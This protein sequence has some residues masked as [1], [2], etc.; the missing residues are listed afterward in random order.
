MLEGLTAGWEAIFQWPTIL[1]PLL[2]ALLGM[3]F[4]ALPGLG[5]PTVLAVLIPLTFR[6]Q[7][8]AAL[9]L[10]AS[11]LGGVAFGGS[12]SAILL[13]TPGDSINAATCFDGYPLAQQGKAGMA[14]GASACASALG[15]LFGL[16]VLI[17]LLPLTRQI[18]LA[19]SYPELV[20]VALLGL[21][22]IAAVSESGR[23]KGLLM[24]GVG[25]ML[26]FV[27][28]N[29]ITATPRF[30]FQLEYLWDGIPLVTVVIGLFAIG[31][32][33]RLY[34]AGGSIAQGSELRASS[35]SI[36]DTFSGVR[37]VFQH[38]GVFLRS[39][40]IGTVI[41][42]IPGVG[43]TVANFLAYGQAVKTAKDPERFGKGDIRGVIASEASNDAKDGGALLPTLAFGIP[44]SAS[45]AVLLGG[46]V[47]HG[48]APG[49]GL[50][51]EHLNL[52][53]TIIFALLISNV[54]TS[55]LGLALAPYLSWVTLVSSSVLSPI[56]VVISL[57]GAYTLRYSVGDVALTVI[58][59]LL[60]YLLS[61]SHYPKV[62]III[63][64]MLG[65]V[66]ERSFH[67][68]LLTMGWTAFFT[69]P[70][71][72]GIVCITAVVLIVPW[73]QSHF[74]EEGVSDRA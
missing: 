40:V 57:I 9:A 17:S 65:K 66:V 44:G 30:T 47:V 5:G 41:G 50:V 73:L 4:G 28:L 53:F 52:V 13:N 12:I 24:G 34:G 27:G 22:V 6:M 32:A 15:A 71:C 26:S 3:V 19:F 63:G 1:F 45:M 16:V 23:L 46:F 35:G 39:S 43:G 8:E 51:S 38:F 11:A 70:I 54:V 64:L 37:A 56:I 7:S 48:I 2:G 59:G 18:V 58:F 62:P 74:K 21:T 36:S 49:P 14:L 61:V 60:G 68:T 67:F 29:P 10:L 33:I 42:A 25:L 69:R 55:V 31:E 20:M 72:M